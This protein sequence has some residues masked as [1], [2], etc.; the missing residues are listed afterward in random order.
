MNDETT[1]ELIKGLRTDTSD[2]RRLTCAIKLMKAEEPEVKQAYIQALADSFDKVVQVS[3]MEL[4]YRGGDDAVN[5]LFRVLKQHS[6]HSRLESCKALITLKAANSQVVSVLEQMAQE[7]DAAKY[8]V[9]I[10]DFEEMETEPDYPE[11]MKGGWGKISTIV[12]QA[13]EVASQN[14]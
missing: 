7:P 12:E 3:C 8:D 4:S 10:Q 6:W 9:L 14:D 1:S 13:R 11:E 2:K 5:A